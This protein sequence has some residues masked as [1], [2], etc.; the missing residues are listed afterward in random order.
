M[1]ERNAKAHTSFTDSD[2]QM[3]IDEVKNAV[4]NVQIDFQG[5]GGGSKSASN[6]SIS[7]FN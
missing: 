4:N 1:E 3:L 2:Y 7:S 6:A 5:V